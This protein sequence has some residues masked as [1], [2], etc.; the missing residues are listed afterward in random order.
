M[1]EAWVMNRATF[2]L[3]GELVDHAD[4]RRHLAVVDAA[5]LLADQLGARVAALRMLAQ[6]EQH[7]GLVV[8]VGLDHVL[9]QAL[10]G[11][12]GAVHRS[13]RRG[14]GRARRAG[15][16]RAR[17]RRAGCRRAASPEPPA[18]ERRCQSRRRRS[19]RPSAAAGA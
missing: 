18:L 9:R 4:D 8:L 10:A 13:G 11:D 1:F 12:E 5:A 6:D 16:R 2:A 17:A 7:H 15:C 14:A 19:R 3:V